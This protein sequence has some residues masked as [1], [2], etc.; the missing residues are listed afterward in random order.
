MQYFY[1]MFYFDYNPR[2]VHYGSIRQQVWCL[3]HFPF[4]LAVVLSVEG[5]RQLLTFYNLSQTIIQMGNDLRIAYENPVEEGKILLKFFKFFY[6]DGNAKSVV[7]DYSKI[8]AT[9]KEFATYSTSDKIY[10]DTWNDLVYRLFIGLTE[11]YGVKAP[12]PKEG[13]API[14]EAD[15]FMNILDVFNLAYQY[16]FISV[17]VVFAMYGVFAIIVR[18]HMDIFDY[19]SIS[20]RFIIAAIFIAMLALPTNHEAYGKYIVSPWLIPQVCMMI[21]VGKF[22]LDITQ[23]KK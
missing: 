10:S 11:F 8:T 2:N 21:F 16:F 20:L 6:N 15:K 1:W 4:H 18:R 19:I 17:G 12:Y 23:K 7:K 14:T 13:A 3:L 9:I 22:P 5:L